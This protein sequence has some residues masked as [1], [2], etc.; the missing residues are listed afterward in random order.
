MS[1][2]NFA[3]KPELNATHYWTITYRSNL[4][5]KKP[6]FEVREKVTDNGIV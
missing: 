4:K 5:H 6:K 3:C 2:T 1:E